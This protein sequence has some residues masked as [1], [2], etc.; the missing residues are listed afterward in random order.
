MNWHNLSERG[1]DI[2]LLI[3]TNYGRLRL[4]NYLPKGGFPSGNQ[5]PSRG[6][7]P[8]FRGG[9]I[10]RDR[11]Q[12]GRHLVATIVIRKKSRRYGTVIR[13]RARIR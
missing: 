6:A 10:M 2:K 5:L 13:A 1:M 11:E 4:I 7:R 9:I 3:T 12:N 8:V